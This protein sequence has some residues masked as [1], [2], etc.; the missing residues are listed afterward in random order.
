LGE[1]HIRHVPVIVLAGVH[2]RLP[3]TQLLNGP[4]HRRCLHKIRPSADHVENVP[5]ADHSI[6]TM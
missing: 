3:D 5:H 1:E 2:Q 6:R 4:Q